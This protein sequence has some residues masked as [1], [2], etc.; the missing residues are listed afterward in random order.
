MRYVICVKRRSPAGAI[1]EL[2]IISILHRSAFAIL[3]LTIIFLSVSRTEASQFTLKSGEVIFGEIEQK[4]VSFLSNHGKLSIKI[5]S[6]EA[7]SDNQLRL[8]DGSILHGSIADTKLKVKTVA[9]TLTIQSKDIIS[10]T[11]TQGPI[12]LEDKKEYPVTKEEPEKLSQEGNQSKNPPPC[13][14]QVVLRNNQTIVGTPRQETLSFQTSLG[15]INVPIKDVVS[16]SEGKLKLKNG[17]TLQ[18]SI[19]QEKLGI[20]TKYG[21]IKVVPSDVVSLQS[22]TAQGSLTLKEVPS[23]HRAKYL[24]VKNPGGVLIKGGRFNKDSILPVL[25][26]DSEKFVV[27]AGTEVVAIQRTDAIM[28]NFDVVLEGSSKLRHAPS[29]LKKTIAVASFENRSNYAGVDAQIIPVGMADQ[30]TDAIVQSGRFIVLDRSMLRAIF[31]EQD[32]ARSERTTKVMGD[33]NQDVVRAA[34]SGELSRAQILVKG[35][36]TEFD[37]GTE[38][39]G[40]AL[41]LYGVT[42]GSARRVAHLAV[43]IYLIDT[44]TGQVL[45]SQRVEGKAEAGGSSFGITSG[46]VSWGQTAFKETP[47]GKAVQIAIDRAI[48]YIS[49]RLIKESW[50]G[51]VAKV[52]KGGKVFINSGSRSGIQLGMEFDVCTGEEMVDPESG[53]RLGMSLEPVCKIKVARVADNFAD[54]MVMAGY[55]PQMNDVVVEIGETAISEYRRPG[56]KELKLEEET[57]TKT[58]KALEEL[59]KLKKQGKISEEEFNKRWNRLL[60]GQ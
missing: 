47:M 6:I 10:I 20:E 8:K 53:V 37:P 50:H 51:R 16:F 17:S 46:R 21:L 43:V 55:E 18:G 5:E 57:D 25:S 39:E 7:F 60:G 44:T 1:H 14:L 23:Q 15:T 40:Q 27:K 38:A 35:S 26:E 56:I 52:K 33:Q 11:S 42:M 13:S 58:Q 32:L 24:M 22:Q 9:T 34:K 29:V 19:Q 45:D 59:V 48:E 54:C 49:G 3:I 36:I 12:A 2:P 28:Q 41:S 4:E 31:A 30:L